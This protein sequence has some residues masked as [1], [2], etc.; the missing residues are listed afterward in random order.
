[1]IIITVFMTTSIMIKMMTEPMR[2]VAQ[3][4]TFL[5]ATDDSMHLVV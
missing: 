4:Q 1:M 2:M 5:V 3:M